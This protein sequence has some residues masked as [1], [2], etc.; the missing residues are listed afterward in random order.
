MTGLFRR[1]KSLTPAEAAAR[2]QRGELQLVDVR[3]HAEL[4]EAS[5]PGA[6]HIPLGQLAAR[7]DELDSR[8]VAFVCRSGSR[9]ALATR[10]AA[11]AGLD[12]TNVRGGLIAWA[13][14]GLPLTSGGRA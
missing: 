11:R 14:A 1:S 12:A 7:L 8:P 3:E 4:A 5:V 10:A 13:R 6:T 2:H 9:S